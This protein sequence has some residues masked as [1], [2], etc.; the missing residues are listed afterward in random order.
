VILVHGCRQVQLLDELAVLDFLL[1]DRPARAV[2][3][4]APSD[5]EKVALVDPDAQTFGVGAREFDD[6]DDALAF[7]VDVDVRVRLE[8]PVMS[9]ASQVGKK[10]VE[11]GAEFV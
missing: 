11:L 6:H 1:I 8:T 10:L 7:A 2:R 3:V 5:D 9:A 4:N